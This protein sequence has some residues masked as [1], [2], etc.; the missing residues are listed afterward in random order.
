MTVSLAALH[1]LGAMVMLACLVVEHL[2]LS[3]P[4]DQPARRRLARID[5]IY[6]LTAAI[7]LATGIGRLFVEKGTAYY[8]A[9]PVFHA[10]MGLFVLVGLASIY[11]TVRILSW[12]RPERVIAPLELR[13]VI[14]VVRFELLA[15]LLLPFLA[16]AMARGVGI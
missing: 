10:K 9:N 12:R 2:A 4:L 11:P 1:I 8:L 3:A 7:Q 15:L 16:S 5:A 13:R 6:G 14:M